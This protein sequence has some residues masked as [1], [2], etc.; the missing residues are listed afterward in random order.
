MDQFVE[1][2]QENQG[3]QTSTIQPTIAA[4]GQVYVTTLTTESTADPSFRGDM[5]SNIGRVPCGKSV[6]TGLDSAA[7]RASLDTSTCNNS[8]PLSPL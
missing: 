3:D 8:W 4:P 5:L 7:N 1:L 6:R 2:M